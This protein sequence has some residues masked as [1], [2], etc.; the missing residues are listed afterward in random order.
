M[1]GGGMISANS[2]H[3]GGINAMFGDGSVRFISE[4]INWISPGYSPSTIKPGYSNPA[5]STVGKPSP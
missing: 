2:Y 5:T 4:N 3:T 1:Q